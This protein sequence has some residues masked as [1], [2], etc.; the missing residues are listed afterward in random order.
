MDKRLQT[1]T[2]YSR[3]NSNTQTEKPEKSEEPIPNV[4]EWEVK[5]AVNYIVRGKASGS[6]KILI[7][8]IQQGKVLQ[9]WKKANMINL[10][11]KAHSKYIKNHRPIKRFSKVMING[12]ESIIDSNHPK[13]LAVFR[14]CFSTMGHMHCFT[15]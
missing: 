6:N 11:E 12:L 1:K 14:R 2:R 10:H 5:H 4:T 3:Y 7:C 9:Q 15:Y 8:A 13:E